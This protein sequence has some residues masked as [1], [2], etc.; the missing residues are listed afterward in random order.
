M[1]ILSKAIYSFFPK[2]ETNSKINVEVQNSSSYRISAQKEQCQRYF[3]N[4]FQYYAAIL[5]KKNSIILFACSA[6]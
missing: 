1:A 4:Q 2:I 5:I 6:S 3:N